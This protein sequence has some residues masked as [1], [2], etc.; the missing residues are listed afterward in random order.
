MLDNA[1]IAALVVLVAAVLKWGAA[2]AGIPLDEVTVN[3][4][5]AAIVTYFLALFGRDLLALAA[6]KLRERGLLK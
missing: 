6:P 5:A 3:N 2:A 1:V 4:L